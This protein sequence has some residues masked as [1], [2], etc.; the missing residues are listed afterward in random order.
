[1]FFAGIEKQRQAVMVKK[2]TN[3]IAFTP[4]HFFNFSGKDFLSCLL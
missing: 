1:M 2:K 4:E 3:A